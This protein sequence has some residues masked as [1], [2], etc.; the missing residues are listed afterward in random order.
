MNFKIFYS[1]AGDL[2][3]PAQRSKDC[4]TYGLGKL[5]GELPN[6]SDTLFWGPYNNDPTI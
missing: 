3:A 1:S 2:E 5:Q 6:I 4:G